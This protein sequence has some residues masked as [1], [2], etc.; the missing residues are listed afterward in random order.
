M[1]AAANPSATSS[2]V[3]TAAEDGSRLSYLPVALFGSIMGL[4]GLAVSWRHAHAGF[5]APAWIGSA[6]GVIAL[7]AFVAL[8]FAYLVKAVTG[9]AHVRAEFTHPI[10]GNL[11][12]TPLISLLLIPLL[13]VDYNLTLARIVWSVG[14]ALMVVFA[15]LIALRWISARQLPA[16]ATP[17]WIVPVV[18]L[19]DIPLAVPV[20]GWSNDLHGLML[21]STAVG[22]F[23]AVPLFTLILS[24]LMFEE[25]L[26]APL[27]ATLMILVAPFSV[28]FS[29]Y[30]TTSGGI[31]AFAASLYML[32]LFILA[33]LLGRLRHLPHSCPFRVAWWAASFPLAASAN[34]ALRYADFALHPVT[35]AIALTLLALASAVIA[36]LLLRT[37]WGIVRGELR[38]LS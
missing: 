28:G 27:Q 1:A 9:F 5:G 21:F 36:A 25:P 7:I 8:A 13:L 29:A 22:L 20:L 32:M 14:A 35:D 33:V 4:T 16:H 19:I 2:T 6:I 30:V 10:A 23:F 38:N 26:P 3:S 11:F 24:R 31:D 15:W 18:G 37:L 12:G 17:T 34:A